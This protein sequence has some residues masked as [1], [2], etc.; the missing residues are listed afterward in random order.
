MF[1]DEIMFK[2][3]LDSKV[4]LTQLSGYKKEIGAG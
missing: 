3:K 4:K 2:I 1:L